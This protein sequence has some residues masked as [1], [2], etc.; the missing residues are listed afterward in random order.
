MIWSLVAIVVCTSFSVSQP[1]SAEERRSKGDRY[2]VLIALRGRRFW[3]GAAAHITAVIGTVIRTSVVES[4][5]RYWRLTR[6]GSLFVR[7]RHFDE[8]GLMIR[9][10]EEFHSDRHTVISEPAGNRYGR[11]RGL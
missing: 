8:T 10:R 11:A 9:L 6:I 2:L 3:Y 7:V 1:N 5:C 4:E